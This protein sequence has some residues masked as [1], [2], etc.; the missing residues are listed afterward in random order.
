MY[1]ETMEYYRKLNEKFDKGFSHG[2]SG[3][4]SKPGLI[5]GSLKGAYLSGY[6]EGQKVYRMK[7]K[8]KK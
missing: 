6:Q 2:K 1:N 8:T 7:V 3:E 4:P 5:Y